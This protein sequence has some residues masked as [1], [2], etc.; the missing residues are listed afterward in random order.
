[1]A[2]LIAGPAAS[3]KRMAGPA[4]LAIDFGRQFLHLTGHE[5]RD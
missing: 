5:R 2:V 3:G 4:D 1:M